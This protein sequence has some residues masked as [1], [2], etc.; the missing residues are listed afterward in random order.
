[1]RTAW[2]S[3]IVKRFA[4]RVEYTSSLWVDDTVVA[5][6]LIYE[7]VLIQL[8]AKLNVE[9]VDKHLPFQSLLDAATDV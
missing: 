9:E 3:R 7:L 1:M 5:L 6:A 8:R 2:N 4:N